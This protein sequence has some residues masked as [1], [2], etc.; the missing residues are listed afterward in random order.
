[1]K[2]LLGRQDGKMNNRAASTPK[3]MEIEQALLVEAESQRTQLRKQKP[4]W[5]ER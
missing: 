1:M 3:N 2:R 4:F 5:T